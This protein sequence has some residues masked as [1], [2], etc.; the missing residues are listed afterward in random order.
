LYLSLWNP[1]PLHFLTFFP[2]TYFSTF[3]L[4]FI[5][6]YSYTDVMYFIFVYYIPFLLFHLF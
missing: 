4:C 6:S 1:P 2:L 3:S 5:V